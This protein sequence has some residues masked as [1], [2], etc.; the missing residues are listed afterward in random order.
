MSKTFDKYLEQVRD[1]VPDDKIEDSIPG[2]L[3]SVADDFSRYKPYETQEEKSGD[4]TTAAWD[5]PTGWIDGFSQLL[6]VEYPQGN[7]PAEYLEDEDYDLYYNVTTSK[8][9]WRLFDTI[10][11]SG[12]K[13]R[14]NYTTKHTC[15][16]G[17]V[18]VKDNDFYVICDM[19]SE[20]ACIALATIYA[21]SNDSTIGADSVHHSTKVSEYQ[22]LAKEWK[23]SWMNRL[24]VNPDTPVQAATVHA[25][26]ELHSGVDAQHMLFHGRHRWSWP[27]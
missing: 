26:V 12:E 14:F 11:A 20:K 25:D 22:K 15:E 10:P 13:V 3:A 27:E 24:G 23:Q 4:G 9:Q 2:I 17:A 21:P 1:Q 16:E 19:A 7:E 8:W 18:T 6:S 5:V